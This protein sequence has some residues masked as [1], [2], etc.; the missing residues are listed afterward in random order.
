ML[1]Y[2]ILIDMADVRYTSIL[3]FSSHID[4]IIHS[5]YFLLMTDSLY[6]V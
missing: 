2:S 5:Y 3:N 1:D 6:L 4:S